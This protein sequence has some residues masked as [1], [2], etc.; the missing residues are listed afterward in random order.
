LVGAVALDHVAS[1]DDIGP[2]ASAHLD[3][4]RALVVEGDFELLA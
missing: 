3:D 4:Y 1:A 2:Q